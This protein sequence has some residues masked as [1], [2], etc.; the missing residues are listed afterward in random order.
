MFYIKENNSIVSGLLSNGSESMKGS[1]VV[2]K[3]A[4][5]FRNS[6][7]N[8]HGNVEGDDIF[9]GTTDVVVCDGFVGNISLK[10][11]EGSRSDDGKFFNVRI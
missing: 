7:L 6:H 5:L 4:E 3:S 11:T 10:T 9:K 8:F 2:K 1:E